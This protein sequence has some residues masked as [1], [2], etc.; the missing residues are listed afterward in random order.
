[1][2]APGGRGR[3][4]SPTSISRVWRNGASQRA[5]TLSGGEQAML[6]IGRVLIGQPD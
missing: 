4:T 6:A 3:S 2:P 5:G 1:M